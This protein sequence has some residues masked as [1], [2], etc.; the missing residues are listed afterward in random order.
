[1]YFVFFFFLPHEIETLP[2]ITCLPR[3]WRR[4]RVEHVNDLCRGLFLRQTFPLLQR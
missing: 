4:Y 3:L 2:A 1:M